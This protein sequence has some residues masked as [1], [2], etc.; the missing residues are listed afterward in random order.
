MKTLI[1]E[2]A[3]WTDAESSKASDVG[4]CRIRTTFKNK[5]GQESYL[6]VNG[7]PPHKN[8]PHYMKNFKVGGWVSHC[9]STENTDGSTLRKLENHTFEYCKESILKLVNSFEIQGG[10]DAIEVR[11]DW[12]G[13]KLDGGTNET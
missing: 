12:N 4:N 10:F 8:S 5:R 1:F 2:G 6:E 7:H 13:F 11:N 9:Y 3:G